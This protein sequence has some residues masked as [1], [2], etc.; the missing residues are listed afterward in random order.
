MRSTFLMGAILVMTLSQAKAEDENTN[1]DRAP[2]STKRNVQSDVGPTVPNGY[3][4]DMSADAPRPRARDKST[5]GIRVDAYYDGLSSFDKFVP[6]SSIPA[7]FANQTTTGGI[8]G[9]E[10]LYSRL[11][12]KWEFTTGIDYMF[13]L[14]VQGASVPIAGAFAVNNQT[15]NMMG[16]KL[17]QIGYRFDVGTSFVITP[18]AGVGFYYGK[19]TLTLTVNGGNDVVNYTKLLCS[20]IAGAR[21]EYVF[22]GS[23]RFA[24]G[25][26]G[27]FF[28]PTKIDD[29]LSQAGGNLSELPGS[30]PYLQNNMDFMTGVGGRIMG[31]VSVY[32]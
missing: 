11:I 9:M 16:I 15:L 3:D 28:L 24:L 2:A 19:D 17:L 12:D 1:A 8:S 10:V 22:P 18:Y 14:S 6:Y 21:A 29:E 5:M 26:A 23:P 20:W 32:F 25:L 7:G 13:Q 31:N 4:E 27:E 30:E